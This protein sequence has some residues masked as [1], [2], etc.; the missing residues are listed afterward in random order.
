MQ[1]DTIKFHEIEIGLEVGYSEVYCDA[2]G[3]ATFVGWSREG[4][5]ILQKEE[6]DFTTIPEIAWN[7]MNFCRPFQPE[8]HVRYITQET[9]DKLHDDNENFLQGDLAM[10]SDM[11]YQYEVT[12]NI[13]KVYDKLGQ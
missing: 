11:M 2:I 4:D 12:L 10:K 7:M 8:T 9:L 1:Q 3:M 13:Q 6:N 5:A